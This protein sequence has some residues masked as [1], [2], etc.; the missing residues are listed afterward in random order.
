[1]ME[2][3]RAG[4]PESTEIKHNKQKTARMRELIGVRDTSNKP[5]SI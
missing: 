1:M 3:E 2:R 4:V 5:V